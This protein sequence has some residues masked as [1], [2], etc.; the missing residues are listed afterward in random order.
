MGAV[1]ALAVMPWLVRVEI[2]ARAVMA[3]V[4]FAT[5]VVVQGLR[6]NPGWI[7]GE[8]L[9]S[10]NWIPF[11]S[12]RATVGGLGTLVGRSWPHLGMGCL[13]YRLTD[14]P[15]RRIL[16]VLGGTSLVVLVLSLGGIPTGVS[17]EGPVGTALAALAAW[18]APW[19][20]G[21]TRPGSRAQEPKTAHQASRTRSA[22]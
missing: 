20:V 6:G 16:A 4:I 10:F 13:A 1:V 22:E 2:R 19:W 15:N 5:V 21:R 17:L 12:H 3:F 18:S 8:T 7:S 9:E 11:K 14:R